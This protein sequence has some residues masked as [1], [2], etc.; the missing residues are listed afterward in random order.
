MPGPFVPIDSIDSEPAM[1]RFYRRLSAFCRVIRFDQRGMGMSSRIG[2]ADTITPSCWAEDAVAVM[3]AIG[4]ESATVL[5]SGFSAVSALLLA[6]D[7][8]D[9]VSHLV[10]VNGSARARWAPDY[11]AGA[12]P[13]GESP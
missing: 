12:R 3:D 2:S 6:A 10:V 9:R 1:Y 7:H 8:P 5:G 4:C 11:E 13:S